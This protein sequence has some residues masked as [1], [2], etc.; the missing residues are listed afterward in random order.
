LTRYRVTP[1]PRTVRV[2]PPWYL[3]LT[4]DTS[5]LI[6]GRWWGSS[7]GTTEGLAR[8]RVPPLDLKAPD[9]AAWAAPLAPALLR[10]GGTEADRIRYGFRHDGEPAGPADPG[11]FVLTGK[12]WGRLNRWV[13]DCGFSLLFTVSA[14]P[15]SRDAEGR[16]D[17]SDAERLVRNTVR[18][19]YPVVAWEFGNEVNAYPF[20]YG[21]SRSVSNRRYLQEFAVFADLIR[22]LAPGTKVVGPASAVWPLV[23]EPNP[24]LPALGRSPAAAFLDALSFHYYPQQ[25]SRGRVAVRR[26][27]P[28]NLLN[29]RAL[30]GSL[31]WVRYAR[32]CLSRGPGS[33]APVWLT[34][35]GHA[36]YGGQ[37]G[38]SDTWLSTPWWLDQ[39]GLL[40][41]AGVET[42]FRQSL[43]G[44][45]Y[46]LL[47]RDD[48]APRTDYFASLLWKRK[49]GPLVFA[50][51]KVEGPDRRLRAWHHGRAD[52]TSCLL[53]VNLH[54]RRSVA[55]NIEGTGLGTHILGP[56]G[57]LDSPTAVL[58]GVPLRGK[59]GLKAVLAGGRGLPGPVTI[60]PLGCAF[61]EWEPGPGAS[62]RP[63]RS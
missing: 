5:V 36:L 59:E 1:D 6:G 11:T 17:P 63:A 22:R 58:N 29:S 56:E 10:V 7:R 13:R 12:L 20:L 28:T 37:P 9:L 35:T 46:G 2:L 33:G 61:V 47:D 4:I 34:E 27:K 24:L 50:A 42:V 55:V 21:W 25:S 32:R 51:P 57:G 52:G 53:L 30:D 45:D 26:A 38:V 54:R 31:R 49:M 60:P 23:G 48:L 43:V 62:G 19:G 15:E 39:L 8:D 40:A 41:H 16:W 18:K 3:S 14:G 44:G